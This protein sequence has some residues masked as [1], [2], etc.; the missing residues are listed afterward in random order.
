M[1]AL[2]TARSGGFD[3]DIVIRGLDL[4]AEYETSQALG[5]R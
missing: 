5:T 3:G 1:I 2:A 4:L